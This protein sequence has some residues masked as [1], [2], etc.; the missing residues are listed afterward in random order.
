MT[1]INIYKSIKYRA[2]N[3]IYN[4]KSEKLPHVNPLSH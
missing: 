3:Q 4:A 1:I 2:V